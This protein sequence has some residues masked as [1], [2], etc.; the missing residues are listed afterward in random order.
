MELK[1]GSIINETDD[2]IFV[3]IER[4]IQDVCLGDACFLC[5][6]VIDTSSKNREHVIPDWILRKYKLHDKK[7]NLPNS[8]KFTYGEYVIPCCKECNTLLG[9][10]IETPISKAYANGFESVQE[11]LR[12]DNHQK[13][14]FIWLALLFLKTH[15][16]DQTLRMHL[17]RK[18]PDDSI[19]KAVKYDWESFHHIYCLSRSPFT[20]ASIHIDSLGSL[21][22]VPLDMLQTRE[23]FDFIDLSSCL[24]LGVAIGDVGLIVAFGDGGAVLD[25][26]KDRVLNRIDGALT[27]P[28]FRELVAHFGCCHLHLRNSPKFMTLTDLQNKSSIIVC[29]YP[30]EP[31]QFEEYQP[32]VFG[33]IMDLLLGE[34]MESKVVIRDFKEKL[35]KGE[36]SFLFDDQGK[37]INNA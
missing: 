16:K 23:A 34:I 4:F 37:F 33:G 25:A 8:T 31:P 5:A 20:K 14:L 17:N 2:F 29:Q 21:L 24:T 6:Q 10:E 7:I 30:D 26:L 11:F 32:I 19:A 22:V 13:K 9:Q 35:L 1:D 3:S 15:L 12:N 28:Q 27:L 18:M 36:L